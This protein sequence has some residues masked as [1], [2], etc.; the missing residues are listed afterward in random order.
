MRWWPVGPLF[1]LLVKIGRRG[2]TY[3]LSNSYVVL[4]RLPKGGMAVVNWVL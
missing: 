1:L 2:V 3:Y 4:P